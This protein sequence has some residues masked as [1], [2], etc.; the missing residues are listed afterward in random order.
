[1]RGEKNE[2][3]FK[4]HILQRTTFPFIC[5]FIYQP[6]CKS[7]VWT[8]L[9]CIVQSANLISTNCTLVD[10]IFLYPSLLQ[11]YLIYAHSRTFLAFY[12][13]LVPAL[14]GQKTPSPISVREN[15][16]R[17]PAP[18][19]L[20]LTVKNRPNPHSSCSSVIHKWPHSACPVTWHCIW[21]PAGLVKASKNVRKN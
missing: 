15:I 1:M 12:F 13:V 11:S 19:T 6:M 8:L 21:R 16:F 2:K 7:L 10:T 9:P 5:L 20:F 4:S 18:F 17:P 14:K 3:Y